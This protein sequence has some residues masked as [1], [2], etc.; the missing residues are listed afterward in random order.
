MEAKIHPKPNQTGQRSALKPKPISGQKIIQ[1][2]TRKKSGNDNK[3]QAEQSSIPAVHEASNLVAE[4]MYQN[5]KESYYTTGSLGHDET[6]QRENDYKMALNAPELGDYLSLQQGVY[7]P[8]NH[9]EARVLNQNQTVSGKKNSFVSTTG[10]SK[11]EFSESTP[12]Q[13][14]NVAAPKTEAK[15]KQLKDGK[16]KESGEKLEPGSNDK[17]VEVIQ[18]TPR[19]AQEDPNFQALTTNVETIAK[20]QSVHESSD[21]ASQKAQSSAPLAKDEKMGTAQTGQVEVMEEAEAETISASKFKALLKKKIEQM[22]L[23]KDMEE[24]DD[25]ENHNNIN[26][27]NASATAEISAKKNE[28][29]EGINQSTNA[30]PNAKAVKARTVGAKPKPKFGVKPKAP[31]AGNAMP[32]KRGAAEVEGP[33]QDETA[34]MDNT[35][36]K[37]GITDDMLAN[38][39]EPKFIDTLNQ[40]ESAKASSKDSVQNFRTDENAKLGQARQEADASAKIQVDGMHAGRTAGLGK[41]LG[42]QKENSSQTTAAHQ[43]VADKI[44]GYFVETQTKV[45]GILDKLDETVAYRFEKGSEI[46]KNKFESFVE[47]GIIKYKAEL[48][49][50]RKKE[51]SDGWF[52]S[53]GGWFAAVGGAIWD[54]IV[55]LPDDVNK[56]FEDGRNHY[57]KLMDVV[58]ENIANHVAKQLNAAKNEIK[59]G[60]DKINTYV[61]GLS[62]ELRKIG[63][64]SALKIQDQF[65]SLESDVNAKQDELIDSLAQKYQEKLEE[66]DARIE[67]I[68]AA[69]SGLINMVMGAI[70]AIVE[71]IIKVK[72]V[73]TNLLAGIV[74]VVGAII[75]D[76]FGFADALFTGLGNGF[77]NFSKNML[78]HLQAGL[79]GWLT[80]TLSG[81]SITFPENIFSLKGIFSLSTQILGF[82]WGVIRNI[83][84]KVIGEPVMKALETGF[85]FVTILKNEGI[86]GLWEHMKD[87]FMDLKETVL[88][89]I[90][91]MVITQVIEAGVKWLLGL[92]NPVGAFVKVVMAIISVVKFFIERAAQIMELVQAF[93]DGVKAVV[94]GNATKVATAVENALAKAV[95]VVIGFL[96]ALLGLGGLASKVTRIIRKIRKRVAKAIKK[97]WKKIKK[98]AKKF[99]KKLGVDKLAKKGKEKLLDARDYL[100]DTFMGTISFTAAD[101]SRHRVYPKNKR[102]PKIIML[103]S[104]PKPI[105]V[106]IDSEIA[107]SKENS[108]MDNVLV[109]E[110]A[111]TY[112]RE[113]VKPI[114]SKIELIEKEENSSKKDVDGA[115]KTAANKLKKLVGV[116]KRKVKGLTQILSRASFSEGEKTKVKTVTKWQDSGAAGDYVEAAPLTYLQGE[117]KGASPGSTVPRGWKYALDLNDQLGGVAYIRGHMLND[118]L[119]GPNKKW[120]LKPISN[121]MNREMDQ[122]IENHAR[123]ELREKHKILFYKATVKK[124]HKGELNE[125]GAFPQT[126]EV[127][128]GHLMKNGKHDANGSKVPVQKILFEQSRPEPNTVNV[129]ELGETVLIR[130]LVKKGISEK[131]V[132]EVIIYLKNKAN[133]NRFDG[134]T[135]FALLYRKHINKDEISGGTRANSV[136]FS[137]VRELSKNKQIKF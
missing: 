40:K 90:K 52:G 69:N 31:L 122:K 3:F 53:V 15:G 81:M 17:S 124:Y 62:P 18:T 104:N 41:V 2:Q 9:N 33:V 111:K 43:A 23:P 32:P 46:A 92:L 80:G 96:A 115:D 101:G 22:E 94:S 25:F 91:S 93:M 38:S 29:T 97:L 47:Y 8:K 60:K 135:G 137:R 14:V 116:R 84:I 120:N 133:N 64:E 117:F 55:G 45:N 88:G 68:K 26:E 106:Q 58:I 27:V 51:N 21:K 49:E 107:I 119:H 4:Q 11:P 100:Y 76:P 72:N 95:P 79:F 67:E 77:K 103:A 118:G 83:G 86:Q 73:L 89:A 112:Y 109:L 78:K 54:G 42:E 16:K 59:A 44:N 66:V 102:E 6:N 39:K 129:N 87:Q 75:A 132:K 71:I 28:A 121:R 20:T 50:K 134:F 7:L 105:E 127:E 128:W 24:A 57:I 108:D 30:K 126:L 99:L 131:F 1:N 125:I 12:D 10:G 114:V 5:L 113:N 34:N 37:E 136:M 74:E 36:Q 98:M 48:F 110:E 61:K 63:K 35:L 85:K 123:R 65:D 13:K 19:S 56:V 70:M 82:T 130:N